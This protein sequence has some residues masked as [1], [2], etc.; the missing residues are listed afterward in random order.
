MRRNFSIEAEE[1]ISTKRVHREAYQVN[2]TDAGFR[3]LISFLD[4]L[5]S[6]GPF[7]FDF[8]DGVEVATLSWD[9]HVY[10]DTEITNQIRDKTL[11]PAMKIAI[12]RSWGQGEGMPDHQLLATAGVDYCG[13][14]G[15]PSV[16][17]LSLRSRREM[18][19]PSEGDPVIRTR[20]WECLFADWDSFDISR[21]PVKLGGFFYAVQLWGYF[22]PDFP[23]RR[24]F[25]DPRI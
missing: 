24:L 18:S 5:L 19:L 11:N 16:T 17:F 20:S 6:R 15:K 13:E 9:G 1:E 3:Y 2:R 8:T 10:T 22:F 25:P 7:S 12:A 23:C 4:D 21:S 14:S